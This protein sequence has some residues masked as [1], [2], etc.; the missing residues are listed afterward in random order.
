MSESP[1][2]QAVPV[3]MKRQRFARFMPAGFTPLLHAKQ[4]IFMKI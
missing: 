2:M 1:M 4:P 3:K